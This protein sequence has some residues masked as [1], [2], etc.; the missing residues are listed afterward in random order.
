MGLIRDADRIRRGVEHASLGSFLSLVILGL[1]MLPSIALHS[2]PGLMAFPFDF[3]SWS[4]FQELFA[5][6]AHSLFLRRRGCI[7]LVV[8]S[9]FSGLLLLA[10]AIWGQGVNVGAVRS[11]T[12][13][14]LPRVILSYSLGMLTFRA[15][16]YR[17]PQWR[18]HP[19]IPVLLLLGVMALP[20]GKY[21]ALFDM[22]AIC[23]VF[24]SLVMLGAASRLSP[25]MLRTAQLLGQTSYA[26]YLIHAPLA[27]Y[28]VPLWTKLFR[29]SFGHD[30]PW[31]VLVYSILAV[32]AAI[33]LD[34]A[35]DTPV[36]KFLRHRFA[37][38]A[39]MRSKVL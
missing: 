32:L 8:V 14:A 19:M 36:R 22:G 27:L 33:L 26:M 18:V 7:F 4:L 28:V 11:E 20:V 25:R 23:C 2:S 16:N 6:A 31:S 24:P 1:L 34:F 12:V 21:A 10:V 17:K 38:H 30:A 37:T 39:E 9:V 5:N 35:Y 3:P 29:N 15:W 13:I